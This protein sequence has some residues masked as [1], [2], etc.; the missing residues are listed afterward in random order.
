MPVD[1]RRD[2]PVALVRA[3]TDGRG[4]DSVLEAVG[5]PQAGRLAFDL[6][7]PGGIISTAGVHHETTFPFSPAQACDR[8]L[9]WRIGR[10]PVR[11]I[12]EGLLPLVR[13]RR[14]DLVALITHRLPLAE[15][16]QGYALFDTRRDGCLKV[17]FLP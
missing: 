12:M 11:S 1:L 7:R 17:A 9:T 10:C 8:N 5:S 13:R 4:A 14:D 15:G 6:V 16:P 2:D 3:E